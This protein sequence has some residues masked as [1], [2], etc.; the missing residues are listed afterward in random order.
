MTEQF[1]GKRAMAGYMKISESSISVCRS[2]P[3]WL[4][5]L[6]IALGLTFTAHAQ[7]RQTTLGS[8]HLS[9]DQPMSPPAWALLERELLRTQTDACREFF[10]KYFD[11]RGFLLCVERW[12]GNDGPDDAPENVGDWPMLHALGGAEEILQMYK[13]AW[14]GH[15]RQYTLAKTTEVPFARDGMYYKEFPVMMDWLHNGEGLRVFNLQ[16]L[17]DPGDRRLEQ[18]I[19]RFAGFYMNEDPGAPNYDPQHKIIRSL[20]NGS[21]GPMLRKATGLDWAG[22]PLEVE[23]RFEALH[24]ERTYDEMIAHFKDYNDV[25]GD[26]PQNLSA[27]TLAA[28][29]YMLTGEDKYKAWLLEYVDAWVERIK[30]NEGIIPSNI[31]L[32]GV[33]GSAAGGKWYGGVYGWGFSVVVPQTGEIGHRNTVSRGVIGF[34][35]ALLLTGERRYVDVWTSMIDTIN[36]NRKV[37]DG[38]TVYPRMYGDEGWYSFSESPWAEGALECYFW[39]C[40]AKDRARVSGNGWLD[41]LDGKNSGYPE[42]ALRSDVEKVRKT[43]ADMRQDHSTPD[44]RLSDNPMQ[45]NPA[46]VG[47]LR[48]LMMAGLDPGRGGGPLHCRVRWFDPDE[49]RA[50]IPQDVAVLI[51]EMKDE[52]FSLTLINLSPTK[53]RHVIMQGGAYGEHLLTAVEI[54]GKTTSVNGPL[55]NIHLAPGAGQRLVVRNKRYACQPTLTFPWDRW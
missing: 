28:N 35:N 4:T 18:R 12:G 37:V 40:A 8:V 48:E 55:L 33:P 44:T 24:G 1:T 11:E 16:G 29:A 36:A 31:G 46:T 2:L 25:A 50:G 27:T 7:D 5:M 23:N 34:G 38:K 52:Q 21:R 45:Y 6:S 19:R 10:E 51:D 43:V 53:D 49:R 3:V 17:S 26:H 22:D 13:K 30:A 39:T 32:D 15:L 14:E 41:Y 54:D 42:A 20:L 9:L 47:A